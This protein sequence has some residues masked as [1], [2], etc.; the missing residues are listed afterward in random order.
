MS[1]VFADHVAADRLGEA[2]QHA[3]LG[4]LR[5]AERLH[6]EGCDRCKRLFA[7]YRLTDRLLAANWREATLPVSALEQ[8]PIRTGLG[9]YFAGLRLSPRSLV[10]VALGLC[11]AALIAFG[12]LLPEL[13]PAQRPPASASQ[14][15]EASP[16]QS[17]GP[18]PSANTNP[19]PA[20][21]AS[22]GGSPEVQQSPNGGAG[23]SPG[24][25][26]G[27]TQG[28]PVVTPTGGASLGL[29]GIVGWPVVWAPDGGHLMAARPSG[30]TAPQQIQIFDS[31]GHLTGSLNADSATWVDSDTIAMATDGKGPGGSATIRLVKVNGSVTATLSGKYNED[32]TGSAGAILLGS[33][34]GMVAIASQG[35]WGQ[36][37]SAFVLWNGHRI[38]SSHQGMPIAFSDDG[39]RLAVLHPAGATGG[40]SSGWLE[41]VSVPSLQTIASYPHTVIH[42]STQGGGVGYA[43]DAAFSPNGNWLFDSGTLVDLSK[44][45]TTAVGEGGWLPDGTL[46]TSEGGNVLRWQG[47]DSATDTALLAG[48]T[49]VTSRH[50]DVVEFFADGRPTLLL[51]AA[52]T[53]RKLDLSGVASIDGARMAPDGSAVA[54][55]GQGTNGGQFTAVIRLS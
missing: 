22:P 33:G 24:S 55:T 11:V 28:S 43:P 15:A 21:F 46:L 25:A 37:G 19:S 54:I 40:T 26:P 13:V 20:A 41:V 51:T 36:T 49:V 34:T 18:S 8:K 45:S 31:S 4:Y 16:S 5:D 7:G 42:A 53:L 10:P 39:S 12:V 47:A 38:G 1:P 9:G 52:G 44:G 50:G 35:G 2:A 29:A 23:N 32:G 27:P 30:W 6:A 14:T 3:S 48:G 17:V